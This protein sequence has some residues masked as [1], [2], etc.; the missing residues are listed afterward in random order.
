MMRR[1]IISLC[2]ALAC[3]TTRES[4][5]VSATGGTVTNYT[6]NGTNFTAHIFTCLGTNTAFTNIVFSEGGSV[7]YLVVAG[8]GRG[9]SRLGGGGGAGGFL[10]G[11]TN[12]SGTVTITVGRGGWRDYTAVSANGSNSV[13]DGIIAVGGGF[14]A[15]GSTASAATNRLGGSGGGGGRVAGNVNGGTATAGQGNVGG[16]GRTSAPIGCGGGGGAGGAGSN[17][18]A[19]ASGS[20]GGGLAS[21]LSGSLTWYAGGGGGAGGGDLSTIAPGVGGSGGGGDGTTNT[22]GGVAGQ[23]NTGGGGGAGTY[24]SAT[25]RPGGFGG[26]GIVIVRYVSGGSPAAAAPTRSFYG[27]NLAI[28]KWK[29]AAIKNQESAQ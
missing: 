14:G 23:A 26:T 15:Y 24:S 28:P 20:G 10:T 27:R 6:E 7:E 19:S 25:D 11:T 21:T 3:L 9:G 12:V 13:F 5:A 29:N 16:N 1:A 18:T 8:G 2:L 4:S 17:A 22:I